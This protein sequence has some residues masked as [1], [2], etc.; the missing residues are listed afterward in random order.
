MDMHSTLLVTGATGTTGARL[1]RRL[2]E[3][4]HRVRAAGRRATPVGGAGPVA[5]DWFAPA[6]HEAALSGVAGIYL[7][8]PIGDPEPATVMLPFLDRA[9]RAGVRRAVLLSSSLVPGGGPGTGAV[10]AALA[11]TFPEWAVLR[12]SWFMQN[13]TGRHPHAESLRDDATLVTATG[14]GRVGFI[15]A[16]DIAAVAARALTDAL[17]HNRDWVLTGPGTLS[18]DEIAA[19]VAGVT[20]RPVRHRAVP[21]AELRERLARE[22]P[23][24]FAALLAGLDRMI[25]E[26]AEDRVTD[27]VERVTGR[28]PRSFAAY[29]L[30]HREAFTA[31]A[32]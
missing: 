13:F 12:P 18:Y 2:A 19:T 22:L 11:E 9:R 3:G 5:F 16:E 25:A 24:E 1:V 4:G 30:A 15:D 21:E 29:A 28:P 7:V 20:G 26:G 31:A 10:H 8:P 32:R 27:A 23:A 6:T 14:H 17:P